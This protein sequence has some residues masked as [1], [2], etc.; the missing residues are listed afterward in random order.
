MEMDGLLLTL[1]SPADNWDMELVVSIHCILT[2]MCA[3]PTIIDHYHSYMHTQ[4]IPYNSINLD[5]SMQIYHS[6]Y[7]HKGMSCLLQ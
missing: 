7:L 5:S 2:P 3:T 1:K 4:W 6:R